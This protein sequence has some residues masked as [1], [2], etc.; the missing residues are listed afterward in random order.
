MSWYKCDI[1]WVD[2]LV[3]ILR[4]CVIEDEKSENLVQS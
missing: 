4:E 1:L 2:D 3:I